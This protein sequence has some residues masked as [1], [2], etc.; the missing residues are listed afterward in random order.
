MLVDSGSEAA[1]ESLESELLELS[2]ESDELLGGLITVRF[3]DF[4]PTFP[5]FFGNMMLN[6]VA[7]VAGRFC[8]CRSHSERNDDC[9]EE[10]NTLSPRIGVRPR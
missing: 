8:R 1:S 4:F 2:E 6:S 3:D 5:C 9:V 7:S 10:L